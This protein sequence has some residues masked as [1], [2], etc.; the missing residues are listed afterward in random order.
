M[1]ITHEAAI[2]RLVESLESVRLR[3]RMWLGT[4]EPKTCIDWLSGL[5]H[6]FWIVCDLQWP[7]ESRWRV[8][9]GRGLE[10]EA[11][12]EDDQLAGRGLGPE[13]IVD[14]LLAIEI[15]MWKGMTPDEIEAACRPIRPLRE[16]IDPQAGDLPIQVG[17]RFGLI[18][19]TRKDAL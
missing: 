16:L 3:P 7:S 15:E 13:E 1:T 4:L 11:R 2:A 9:K 17:D 10:F 19:R 18:E 8:L 12:W 14:E 5:R 6:G